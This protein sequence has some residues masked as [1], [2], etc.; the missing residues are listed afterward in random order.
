[1][2]YA[3]R[4]FTSR[5]AAAGAQ[6]LVHDSS[7]SEAEVERAAET[8][9]STARQAALLAEAAGVAMLAL[10]HI[11]ARHFIPEIREQLPPNGTYNMG[12]RRDTPPEIIRQIEAAFAAAVRSDGFR[13]V[14]EERNFVTDL[15][16]GV[17]ADRRAAEL[18][19][20]SASVFEELEIPGAKTAGELGL[21][22]PEEFDQWW[23]PA[24][25]TVLP[26][27]DGD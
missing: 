7:F 20:I 12:V 25:Y 16:L 5:E 8:G 26:I 6:L 21:P 9:H 17:Q 11:S 18:E 3:N 14:V 23:P 4:R 1:M 24:R 10:V 19:T 27:H 22:R 15:M 13:V 2:C